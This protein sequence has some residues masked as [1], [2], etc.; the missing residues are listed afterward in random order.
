VRQIVGTLPVSAA[1]RPERMTSRS[2]PRSSAWGL[3]QRTRLAAP[4]S[5]DNEA[6]HAGHGLVLEEST[7]GNAM[8]PLEVRDFPRTNVKTSGGLRI[9]VVDDEPLIRWSLSETLAE[10]GHFV[11]ET[12]DA[13]GARR[14]VAGDVPFDV[15]L[16]DFRLPDS[17]DLSLLASMRQAMPTPQVILMTAFGRPEIVRGALDLG[18]SRVINKPFEMQTLADLVE[19]ASSTR[20]TH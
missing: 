12:G 7:S 17:D 8:E 9:L 19:A 20:E 3:L 6:A 1:S 5:C 11:V 18:V 4:R 13:A 10:R 14:A 15:V 2:L 16:L